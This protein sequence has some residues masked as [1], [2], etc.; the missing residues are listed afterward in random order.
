[1]KLL[2]SDRRVPDSD[3]RRGG[4]LVLLAVALL[5]LT[6][7]AGAATFWFLDRRASEAGSGS[8]S[9][10]PAAGTAE[11]AKDEATSLLWETWGILE[12]EYLEP[13]ALVPEEMA[14]GAAAGAVSAVHDP[15]TVFVDPIPAAIMDEDMQGTFEGIGATVAMVE[16]RL[17]IENLIADS[18]AV[19]AGLLVGDA[20]LEVDGK[21]LEGLD[22]VA[23]ITL[24]RGPRGSVVRLLVDREGTEEPF[25][26]SVTRARVELPT[27]E[28]R[29]LDGGIAYLRLTEFNGIASR[30]VREALRSLLDNDPKGLV[31][32]L[33]D[34]PGGY[35]Q[36]SID[37][38][39]EFLDVGKVVVSERVR[40]QEPE[41]FKVT[42]TGLAVDLPLVV[43]V[44]G[45]SASASEIVA[46]A[47]RDHERGVL[48]GEATYG[49]GSVQNVHT[50]SDG[51]SLR[52]TVA[53]YYLP[54]G[55]NLD[56]QG[57]VPDVE[58]P[59]TQED[60]D[61]QRDPQLDRAAEYLAQGG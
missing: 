14:R 28:Y 46:G 16:G 10:V 61:A 31:L 12:D 59:F 52:V 20:I 38:A 45:G 1:M 44:N 42:R 34:N 48:I 53:R 21:S 32:D 40:D 24:I 35:F 2:Q 6:F 33:R 29:M 13:D 4:L 15:F 41:V 51:S 5:V 54:D 60:A 56:G 37:V 3:R 7:A 30:K 55:E 58:V 23:A 47:I 27:V 50:L 49:K 19:K 8:A 18:P 43:L 22:V 36:A 26:V 39:S 9:Q 11:S 25:I 57:L 17:I